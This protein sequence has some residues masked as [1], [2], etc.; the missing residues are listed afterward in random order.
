[1]GANLSHIFGEGYECC[2]QTGRP[3]EQGVGSLSHEQQTLNFLRDRHF[4][5]DMPVDGEQCPQTG[6]FYEIGSG[7]LSRTAQSRL[8]LQDLSPAQKK[9]RA[10]A[11]AALN[12]IPP[13]GSA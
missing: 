7:A 6:R 9:Q 13:A 5:A 3:Y 2:P 8:F 10:E 1:M 12:A 11:A 4:A